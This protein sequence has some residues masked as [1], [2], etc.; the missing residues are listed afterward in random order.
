MLSISKPII[1]MGKVHASTPYDSVFLKKIRLSCSL[2]RKTGPKKIYGNLFRLSYHFRDEHFDSKEEQEKCQKIIS[3]LA[4]LIE[5]GVL[6][7]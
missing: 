5:C 2:C 1:K 4:D 6:R 7:S 3:N